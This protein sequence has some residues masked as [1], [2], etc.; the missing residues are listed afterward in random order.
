MKKN[1]LVR[2]ITIGGILS[3]IAVILQSAPVYLPAIGLALSPFSTLPIA[4]AAHYQISLGVTALISSALL[5]AFVSVQESVILLFTTGLFGIVMG[6]LL[7]RK[8]ILAS[9]LF[10]GILL[11]AGMIMLTFVVGI[12][13]FG[14]FTDS[15]PATIICLIFFTFSM[16]YAVLW[17]ICVR[18]I[19]YYFIKIKLFK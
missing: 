16:L 14:G 8:G 5:L 9:T 4:I 10:S 1:N 18:K 2:T 6:V 15:L 17:N 11:S 12:P 3:T 19:I 7:F 13:A